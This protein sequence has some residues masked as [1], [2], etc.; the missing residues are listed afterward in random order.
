MSYITRSF[1]RW[2]PWRP[3]ESWLYNT[4]PLQSEALEAPVKPLVVAQQPVPPQAPTLFIARPSVSPLLLPQIPPR[5]VV[6]TTPTPVQVPFVG[7][8]SFSVDSGLFD[9]PTPTRPLAVAQQPPPPQPVFVF[10]GRTPAEPPAALPD[11]PSRPLIVAAQPLP[12]ALPF[13]YVSQSKV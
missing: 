10:A 3:A 9:G 5:P 6:A 4:V 2:K 1:E 7:Y 8:T 12:A 11:A 13:A